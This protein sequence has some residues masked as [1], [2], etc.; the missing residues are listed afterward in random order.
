MP[1]VPLAGTWQIHTSFTIAP[2]F[3]TVSSLARFGDFGVRASI[4]HV[5]DLGASIS[6]EGVWN[7]CPTHLDDVG[8]I[9]IETPLGELG[10]G[11]SLADKLRI[12]AATS[13][14]G[15]M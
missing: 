3:G 6:L 4:A 11:T 14:A 12:G 7:N 8:R 10:V 5:M 9:G 1:G 13:L 15:V 2:G